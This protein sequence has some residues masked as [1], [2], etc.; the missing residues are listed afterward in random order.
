MSNFRFPDVGARKWLFKFAKKHHWRVA[1]WIDFDDLVQEGYAA[2]Y[3]VLQR[4][5]T[6]V[7]PPHIMR[8]FQLVFRSKIEN[9]VRSNSKQ[10]DCI[11]GDGT[12]Y[13]N[14]ASPEAF[15]FC[16]LMVNAP[17]EVLEVLTLFTKEGTLEGLR[18]PPKR[19]KGQRE[20]MNERLCKLL[21]K[22]PNSTNVVET[23]RMWFA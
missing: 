5:P 12:E 19:N 8:L 2:Y 6:A 13:E 10:V 1:A 4:Y 20:T 23:L 7:D 11:V 18:E 17:Q 9:I 14:A 21:G 16:A 3:E 22:D 15:D